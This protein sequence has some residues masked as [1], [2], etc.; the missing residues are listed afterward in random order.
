MATNANTTNAAANAAALADP[1]LAAA[2]A[3]ATVKG[4]RLQEQYG[5]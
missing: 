5:L 1:T 2:T 4:L 3:D